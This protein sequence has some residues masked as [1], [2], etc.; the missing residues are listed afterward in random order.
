M[1]PNLEQRLLAIEKKLDEN[2]VVI[3]KV[4][5]T[6][7]IAAATKALYWM[8]LIGLGVVSISFIKPYFEQIKTI[9]GFSSPNLD[10]YSELIKAIQ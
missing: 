7:Q 2:M 8:L 1:D 5:R 6:Q 9:Y 10:N 4:R 3:K